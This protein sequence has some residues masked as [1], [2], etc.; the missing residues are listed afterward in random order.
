MGP[1]AGAERPRTAA[2]QPRVGQER[3]GSVLGRSVASGRPVTLVVV[4]PRPGRDRSAWRSPAGV[5]PTNVEA[6]E[7]RK[8]RYGGLPVPLTSRDHRAWP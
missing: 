3:P 6:P 4:M 5:R 1:S 7:R 2:Q 8:D